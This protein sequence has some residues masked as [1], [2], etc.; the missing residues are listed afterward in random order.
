MSQFFKDFD[1]ENF[2]DNSSFQQGEFLADRKSLF[3]G[4]PIND[5][6]IKEL[7]QNLGYKLPQSY[8]ELLK[9]QNGGLV[10]TQLFITDKPISLY[11]ECYVSID[12]IGGIDKNAKNC[13]LYQCEYLIGYGFPDIGLYFADLGTDHDWLIMDYREC[14]NNGEPQISYICVDGGE[15]EIQVI[16]KDFETFIKGLKNADEFDYDDDNCVYLIDK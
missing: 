15:P 14:G 7:E 8:L 5:E 12:N 1:F 9:T 16:A 6:M 13:S 3:I 10:Q 2:W 11:G 4:K